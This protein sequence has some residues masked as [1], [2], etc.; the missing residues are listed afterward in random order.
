MLE[1]SEE[2]VRKRVQQNTMI[3]RH[4]ASGE[5]SFPR[6]QFDEPSKK[7][8]AGIQALLAETAPWAPGKQAIP[9]KAYRKAETNDF[10]EETC[11]Q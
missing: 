7:V 5:L 1:T 8:L 9:N 11:R 6:F 3:A 2:A 10:E 4:T